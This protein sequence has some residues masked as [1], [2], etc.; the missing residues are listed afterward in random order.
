[1]SIKLTQ[2]GLSSP[3]IEVHC[4][5]PDILIL[6]CFVCL[7]IYVY[8]NETSKDL[9]PDDAV[10]FIAVRNLWSNQLPLLGNHCLFF[11]SVELNECSP[12]LI[13]DRFLREE[14]RMVGINH[15]AKLSVIFICEV[16]FYFTALPCTYNRLNLQLVNPLLLHKR[17]WK[18][19]AI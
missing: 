8:Y 7:S 10:I 3:H 16:L 13:V 17:N 19:D 11:A 5:T 2:N 18:R 9:T 4:K 15:C 14:N 6:F 1:M 12:L